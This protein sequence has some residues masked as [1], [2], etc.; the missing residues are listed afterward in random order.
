LLRSGRNIGR[1]G[2]DWRRRRSIV[3]M[4]LPAEQAAELVVDRE[5]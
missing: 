4:K 3:A 5:Q 2:K 1:N